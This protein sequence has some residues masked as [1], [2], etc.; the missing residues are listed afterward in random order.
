MNIGISL[1]PLINTQIFNPILSDEE[2]LGMVSEVSNLV[3]FI[4]IDLTRMSKG[5][6]E[7]Y[8]DTRRLLA[9]LDSIKRV[10]LNE[11]AYLSCVTYE[12]KK[13]L[14]VK[15]AEA[16]IIRKLPK[17]STEK[18]KQRVKKE[19]EKEEEAKNTQSQKEF[20]FSR[21]RN[22]SQAEEK[23]E[24]L[25]LKLLIK[26]GRDDDIFTLGDW[27]QIVQSDSLDGVIL[28][29][30]NPPGSIEEV[31]LGKEMKLDPRILRA[32]NQKN[33]IVIEED[34]QGS[35]MFSGVLHFQV[36]CP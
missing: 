10:A 16:E 8:K 25:P 14:D 21:I 23:T 5:S 19:K 35:K 30:A 22:Y 24:G 17:E 1:A 26:I 2:I 34:T 15:A 6:R 3:D 36:N 31:D 20:L 12:K 28:T 13:G 9:L 29:Q 32:L 33:K 18:F 7:Y 27:N 4:T 11:K